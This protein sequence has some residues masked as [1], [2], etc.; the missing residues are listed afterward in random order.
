[1]RSSLPP[2][3]SFF[4][5]AFVLE[6]LLRIRKNGAGMLMSVIKIS[7][8]PSAIP[9]EDIVVVGPEYDQESR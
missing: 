1:M 5:D 7:A 9:R 8:C 4:S 3:K 6:I 2:Q